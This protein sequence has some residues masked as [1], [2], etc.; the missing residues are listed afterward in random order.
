VRRCRLEYRGRRDRLVAALPRHVAPS[1]I[2]AGLH[3][4][5]RVPSAVEA[6][7]PA[8]ARRHSVGVEC[9]SPMWMREVEDPGGIVVGYGATARNAFAPALSALVAMLGEVSP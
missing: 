4:V 9:L 5:L 3:V 1:G 6:R 7:V 8:A 2:S